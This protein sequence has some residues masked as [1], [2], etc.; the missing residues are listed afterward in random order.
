MSAETLV[1]SGKKFRINALYVYDTFNTCR[2][3][4]QSIEN[5]NFI[6]LLIDDTSIY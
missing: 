1:G 2:F 5:L 4:F 6:C 3:N